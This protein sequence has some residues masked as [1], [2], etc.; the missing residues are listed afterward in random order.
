MAFL[1]RQNYE[2]TGA[3]GTLWPVRLLTHHGFHPLV[4]LFALVPHFHHQEVPSSQ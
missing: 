3:A 4:D 2:L 1:L